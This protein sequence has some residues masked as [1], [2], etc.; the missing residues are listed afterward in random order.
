MR[1]DLSRLSLPIQQWP[2][3]DQ[4]LWS[5]GLREGGPFDVVGAGSHWSAASRGKTAG[6]YG[7]WL[8]WLET[9]GQCDHA[10]PPGRR[11]TQDRVAAYFRYLGETLSPGTLL[12]RVQE[13][14][15]ALRVLALSDE[16]R[17]LTELYRTVASRA[18]P[19]RDKRQRLRT[20]G[21]LV[22][23]G[24]H[25]MTDAETTA[26]RSSRRRAVQYRDG[27]MIALLAYRPVRKK[28]FAAMRVGV[29]VVEQEGRHWILFSAAET[30]NHV[31]YQVSFPEAPEDRLHRYLRH[32]RPIL[33]AGLQGGGRSDIDALW[34]SDAHERHSDKASPHTGFGMRRPRRSP[35]MT[36]FM[37]ATP[38]WF[39]V[40]QVRPPRRSTTT[41]PGACRPPA[42][43]R[44]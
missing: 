18:R 20:A 43:I 1:L 23:L 41:R 24:Q 3:I 42:A 19:V 17:W 29:H 7:R 13:L 33:L 14:S 38:T 26:N 40:M 36:R 22:A 8:H 2:A 11:V 32:H 9:T 37:S 28:N 5:K 30:K 12:C 44:L 27:L 15:D 34:V 16:R 31:A 4:E 6:G 10:V 25:L 35:S 21:E 39:S